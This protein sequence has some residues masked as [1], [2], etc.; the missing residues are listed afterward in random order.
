MLDSIKR[1]MDIFVSEKKY[2]S[3]VLW[4]LSLNCQTT[5]HNILN[6]HSLMIDNLISQDL[7]VCVAVVTKWTVVHDH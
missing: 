1:G 2:S 5:R 4:R 3:S 7:Y 6:I